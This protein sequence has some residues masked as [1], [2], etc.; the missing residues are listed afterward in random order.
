MRFT[1]SKLMVL[2]AVLGV[3]IGWIRAFLIAEAIGAQ[4]SQV[5]PFVFLIFFALQFGLWRYLRTTGRRRRFWLAFVVSGIATPVA[6][7]YLGEYAIDL[8][9]WYDDTASEFAYYVLPWR[10]YAELGTNHTDCWS[11]ILFLLPEL[12]VA[13]AGGLLAACLFRGA[14]VVRPVSVV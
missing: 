2:T 13:S 7:F 11:A 6:L 8:M 9:T 12:I 4:L 3:N 5:F 14:G 1:I 10:I